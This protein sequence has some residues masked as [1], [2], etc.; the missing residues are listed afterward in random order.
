MNQWMYTHR[1]TVTR[2]SENSE[3]A[4]ASLGQF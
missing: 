4:L 2:N 3:I 1:I